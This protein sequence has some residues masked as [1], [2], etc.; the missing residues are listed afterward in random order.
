MGPQGGRLNSCAQQVEHRAREALEELHDHV[1]H[2]GVAHDH[3]RGVQRQVPALDVA[4]EVEPAAL[5]Q[6]RSRP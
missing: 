6:R 1:A 5:E 2:R 3:V 4:H